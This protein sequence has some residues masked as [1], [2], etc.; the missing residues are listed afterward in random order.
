MPE[1]TEFKIEP[2]GSAEH[3]PCADCGG[4]TRSVWGYAYEGDVC[5]AAYFARWTEGHLERG[6]QMLLSLGRW[7]DG[8][9]PSMRH[10]IAFECRMSRDRPA[11]MVIDSS[12]VPWGKDGVLGRC[13]SRVDALSDTF[14]DRAFQILDRVVFADARVHGFLS[15][16]RSS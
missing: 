6:A 3:G 16:G 15:E 13:L 10:S 11:F 7:G 2:D 5:V 8:A 12:T 1:M 4:T 9:D 14:R